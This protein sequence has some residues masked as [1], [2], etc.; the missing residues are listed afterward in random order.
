[1]LGALLELGQRLVE[2]PPTRRTGRER[3]GNILALVQK[4]LVHELLR[5]SD[6]GGLGNGR[7]RVGHWS[8]LSHGGSGLRDGAAAEMASA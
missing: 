2:R 7:G 1:M 6:F 3:D 8:G 4:S 5:A